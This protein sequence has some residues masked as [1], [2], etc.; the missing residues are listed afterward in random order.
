M[1]A[2]ERI[3][4]QGNTVILV[5]HEEDIAAHAHRVVRLRD[6]LIE[7]DRR[8]RRGASRRR[9]RRAIGRIGATGD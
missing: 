9:R 4:E 3:Y 7:S 5:T 8:R 6:G 1:A 2:F